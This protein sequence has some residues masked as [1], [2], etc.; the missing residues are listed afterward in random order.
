MLM[1]NMGCHIHI[2]TLNMTAELQ[3]Y[4][5]NIINYTQVAA[6]RFNFSYKEDAFTET[7]QS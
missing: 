6:R 1:S 4:Q 2:V 5:H 3:K 7:H